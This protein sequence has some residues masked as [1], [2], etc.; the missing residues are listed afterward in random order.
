M[1]KVI[2]I[3]FDRSYFKKKGIKVYF[4]AGAPFS[5]SLFRVTPKIPKQSRKT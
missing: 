2:R 5:A 1:G 3:S 4:A